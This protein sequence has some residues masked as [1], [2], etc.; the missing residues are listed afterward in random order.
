MS[1][2]GFRNFQGLSIMKQKVASLALLLFIAL[3]AT[4]LRADGARTSAPKKKIALEVHTT[5]AFTECVAKLLN[6]GL[7]AQE[8]R[9]L[10][11]DTVAN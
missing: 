3:P 10:C 6:N 11:I 8:A 4:G 5:L 9:Q 1:G 7:G 2:K